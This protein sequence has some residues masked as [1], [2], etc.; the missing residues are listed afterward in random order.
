[1]PGGVGVASVGSLAERLRLTADSSAARK[2]SALWNRADGDFA[3]ARSTMPVH[4]A[5]RSGMKL[6]IGVGGSATCFCTIAIAVSALNGKLRAQQT[7]EHDA[8]RI[9]IGAA[10]D[11][12]PEHLLRRHVRRACPSCSRRA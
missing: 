3:S 12:A 8:D 5:G 4:H 10:V 7:I 11:L 2:S 6:T 9:E 1:M